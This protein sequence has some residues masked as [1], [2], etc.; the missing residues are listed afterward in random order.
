MSQTAQGEVILQTTQAEHPL[1]QQVLQQDY[2]G[3]Y[4]MQMEERELFKYPPLFRLIEMT[5]KHRNLTVLSDTAH[6]YAALLRKRLGNRVVGPDQPAVGKVQGLHVQKIV[7]KI[8]HSASLT[9]VHEILEQTQMQ[10]IQNPAYRYV[11]V[12]YDVD[13]V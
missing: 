9:A 10:M 12:Q 2:A 6:A 7:L 13:P 1:I 5:L 11:I 3:M 8:E 4:R